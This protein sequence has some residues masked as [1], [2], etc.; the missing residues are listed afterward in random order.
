MGLVTTPELVQHIDKK[1]LEKYYPVCGCRLEDCVLITEDGH[2]NLTT[3]PKGDEMFK[4]ING[5]S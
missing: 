5:E 3:A 1:V 2:E 4:V